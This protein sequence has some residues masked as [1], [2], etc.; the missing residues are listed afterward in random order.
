MSPDLRQLRYFVAVAE[1]LN[2]RQAAEDM[3]LAQPAL[4]RAIRQL[5][6]ELD[7]QLFERTTRSVDLTPVGELFL[8][9]ARDVLSSAEQAFAIGRDAA[10]GI[11]GQLRVGASPIARLDLIPVLQAAWTDARPG[12]AVHIAEA[13]TGP[14]LKSVRTGDLDVAVAWCPLQEQG[15]RYERLRDEPV[16]AHV[17]VDH[18]LAAKES[19][20]LEQLAGETILVGSG[21]ASRGY[22]EAVRALFA[23]AGLKPETLADPYPDFGLL[24]AIEGR[25]IVLG[26]PVQAV[27][28]REDL[29]ILEVT[30]P[31]TLPF[32]LVYRERE[33]PATLE[34]IL[35]IA[36]QV[37]GSL[38]WLNTA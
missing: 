18:R 29:V 7:V 5:E 34:A 30:P 13:A 20:S 28:E 36:R 17:A 22:T 19:V 16:M 21:E 11:A 37:R 27:R 12:I 32:E 8:E 9:R 3:H 1:T 15:L 6:A 23:D 38:G 4:S 25:A 33:L 14:L 2:F 10:V 24:A 31:S 35:E 26:S